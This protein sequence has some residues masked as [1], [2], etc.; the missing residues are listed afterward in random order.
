[1]IRVAA[2]LL[3]CVFA[4]PVAAETVAITG[5]RVV[6][7][8]QGGDIERGT[9]VVRDGRIVAVGANVAVPPDAKIIDA[10]GKVVTPGL[11]ASGTA[12]GLIEVRTVE[13]T[14]DRGTSARDLSAAF[15]AGYGLNPD[16]LLIPVARLGGITRAIATPAYDDQPARELLFAGQ[17]AAIALDDR[18]ILMQRGVAMVLEMGDAGAERAGGARAAELV[19]LRAI[20]AEVRDFKARRAAYDRGETRDYTLSRVDL[21][22]LIPVVEGRMPL[23]VSVNRAS[24]IRDVLAMARS[25]RLKLILE[26]ASEGWRVAGD[27]AAAGVPV[28]V[29]PVENTPASFE[30]LGS[31]LSNARRLAEAGVVVAIEGN[32]NHREREMRYNAGNAVASGLDWKTALAAITINPARIFG[33]SDRIGSL[34]PGKDGDVAIWDGDPLDTLSRPVAVLIRGAEQP[35]HSRGTELRDRYLST[36]L[37]PANGEKP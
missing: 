34:E 22:A 13:T 3:A 35:M 32:G 7:M 37:S 30:A 21:E 23:L 27:I 24:D 5:G 2:A 8:G 14:D 12:L 6:T 25:E 10:S 20:F 36:V 33:L 11:V 29:T 26:G 31:T 16:S 9:V 19:A 28:L 1:M 17:A 15:D 18:P 4:F